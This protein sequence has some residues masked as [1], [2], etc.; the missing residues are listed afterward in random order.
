VSDPFHRENL[1]Q[2]DLTKCLLC[3]HGV[4]HGNNICFFLW[5]LAFVVATIRVW[6]YHWSRNCGFR[7][8]WDMATTSREAFDEGMAPTEALWDCHLDYWAP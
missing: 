1:K 4:M 7:L 2:A 5:R 3:G 8:A 6:G